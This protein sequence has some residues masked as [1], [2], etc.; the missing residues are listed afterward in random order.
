[1]NVLVD[2]GTTRN[3]TVYIYVPR[4]ALFDHV[5]AVEESGT[6]LGVN[7]VL[8]VWVDSHDLGKVGLDDLEDRED[9]GADG[10]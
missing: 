2:N 8:G 6:A 9:D 5:S 1:M 10:R 4:E 3:K 7:E